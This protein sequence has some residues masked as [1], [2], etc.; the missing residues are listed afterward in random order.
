[1]NTIKIKT[2]AKAEMLEHVQRMAK[3]RRILESKPK[4]VRALGEVKSAVPASATRAAGV[5]LGQP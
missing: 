3:E 2:N 4:P 5:G 1:M